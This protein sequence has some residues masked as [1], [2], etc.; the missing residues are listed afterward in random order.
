MVAVQTDVSPPNKKE[1]FIMVDFIIYFFALVVIVIVVFI[2]TRKVLMLWTGITR[3]EATK[4]IQAFVSQKKIYQLATDQ[5]LITD[6]WNAVNDILGDVRFDEL[7]RLSKTSQMLETSYASGLPYI[8]V[9][10]IYADDNEKIRIEHILSGIVSRYLSIHGMCNE[11]LADWKQN[12]DLRMPV[13][14]I[15]YAETEEQ[16]KILN[17]SIQQ[18]KSKSISKYQPLTDEE[19]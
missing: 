13:L 17:A 8:A 5:M 10:V 1:I 2:I 7:R 11:V 15:R 3:E 12:M 16:H 6:I 14:M 9:T 18:E 19:I 4:R